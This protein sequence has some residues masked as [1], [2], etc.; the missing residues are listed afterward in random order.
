MNH[1]IVNG[2]ERPS[3]VAPGQKFSGLMEF[4]LGN[5]VNDAS[6]ISSIA[7]NGVEL[8][9]ED[10]KVYADVALADL[11]TVE[12][13]LMHPREMAED[14]LQTLILFT[15]RLAD[16]SRKAAEELGSPETD[17]NFARLIDGMETFVDSVNTVKTVL[18]IAGLK[19]VDVLEADMLSI[20]KDVLSAR[21][22]NNVDYLVQ[23]LNDHLP[24]NLHDWCVDGLPAMI[25]S[26]DS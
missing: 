26:R 23:L 2:Q 11:D 21:E 6:L 3:P 24:I 5:Y 16:M 22:T 17:A 25:R 19:P 1:F 13:R 7:V 14:T 4:L 12:V 18:R 9:G 8:R 10:E 15:E 20:M